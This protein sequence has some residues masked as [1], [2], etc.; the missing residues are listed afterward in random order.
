MQLTN[1]FAMPEVFVDVIKSTMTDRSL[2]DQYRIG[3]T[4]LIAPAR[5]RQLTIRH[6]HELEEDVS[7]HI[8]RISGTAMHSVLSQTNTDKRLVEEMFS[9][10]VGEMTIVGKLDLYD[11]HHKSI[12]D[13]KF[14]SIWAFKDVK[15]EWEDQ[16]NIYAWMLRKANFEVNYAYINGLLKDWSDTERKR[17]GGDYPPIPFKRLQV[18]L[19]T[20]YEQQRFVEDRVAIHLNAIN[21]TD[22]QLPLCSDIERWFSGS[23]FAVMKNSNKTATRLLNTY[24]EATE[25]IANI[26][27]TKGKYTIVKRPGV[28]MKCTRYCS[29]NKVCDYYRNNYGTKE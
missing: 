18:P 14:S 4:T 1:R 29:C 22:A 25:Y 9:E 13:W 23:K 6:W 24:E 2:T 15:K 26:E 3:V 5:V 17:F 21:L 16:L 10:K 19:W 28:D 11:D 7:D 27:D 20:F 12:E 8:W